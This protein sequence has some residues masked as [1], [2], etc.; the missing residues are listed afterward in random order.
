VRLGSLQ[1]VSRHA[2]AVGIAFSGS[3]GGVS[4][5]LDVVSSAIDVIG[6]TVPGEFP[7]MDRFIDPDVHVHGPWPISIRGKDNVAAG[8]RVILRLFAPKG[9]T[10]P[11]AKPLAELLQV[12]HLFGDGEWVAV[13]IVSLIGR[14]RMRQRWPPN[15]FLPS[16]IPG[17]KVDED[18]LAEFMFLIHVHREL[19]DEVWVVSSGSQTS[20]P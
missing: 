15:A 1:E 14:E 2:G 6:H 7:D 20:T 3:E 8:L 18:P 12:T 13:R 16:L 19:I 5:A 11:T 17:A 10:P 9:P 4:N